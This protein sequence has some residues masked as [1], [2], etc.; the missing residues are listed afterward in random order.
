MDCPKRSTP[1]GLPYDAIVEILARLPARSV[2]RFKCVAK[3]WR[4]L[5]DDPLNRKKLPQTLEGFFIIDI[6]FLLRM[7][8]YV[9][10]FVEHFGFINLLPRSVPLD[11][12]P[13]FS[14]LRKRP[15]IENLLFSD[16]CNGL[17]LFDHARKSNLL[18]TLGYIVCNPATKQCE[19][20]STCSCCPPSTECS[21][22]YTRLAFDPAVSSH[23]HLIHFW[24]KG[25]DEEVEPLEDQVSVLS[26]CAYSSETGTWSQSQ[27]DWNEQGQLEGWR[28]QGIL[29]YDTSQ[30]VFFNCVLHVI[31][32]GFDHVQIVALDVQGRTQRMITMPA[33]A[34][35]RCWKYKGYIG[36]SQGRLH[37]INNE[38]DAHDQSCE[39]SIWVLQD[40]DRQEWLLKD[41]ELSE[42]LWKKELHRQQVGLL[43][44]G[45]SSRLQCGFLSSTPEPTNSI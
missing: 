8:M 32:F 42:A 21:K 11:I 12:D 15:E 5:I 24:K 19:T 13:R 26:V 33:A 23:F 36:H 6:F 20:V 43:S 28:H 14:F 31:L 22:W 45:H 40:Y 27:I 9:E 39:L 25:L 41:T 29:S 3:A 18:D 44:C 17:L 37:Y 2:Y 34:E 4:D 35:G 10:S 1:A 7:P 16:S 38:V 30:Y